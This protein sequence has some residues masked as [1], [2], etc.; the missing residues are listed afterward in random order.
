MKKDPYRWLKR[1]SCPKDFRRVQKSAKVLGVAIRTIRNW[2]N[3]FKK[4]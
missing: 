1:L 4:K 2:N 3:K